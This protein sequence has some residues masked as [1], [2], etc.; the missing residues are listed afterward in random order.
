M[1]PNKPAPRLGPR[2]LAL[3]LS[4]ATTNWLSSQGALT[5]AKSGSLPWSKNLAA[6]GAAL[7]AQL[8][9]ANP[10]RLSRAI[11]TEAQARFSQFLSG[12]TAYRAHPYHRALSDPPVLWRKGAARL[13]DYGTQSAGVPVLFEIGRAHV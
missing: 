5:L 11:G 1:T 10:E 3:H 8:E 12:I 13:L 2:P 7:A 9:N 4:I 6:E